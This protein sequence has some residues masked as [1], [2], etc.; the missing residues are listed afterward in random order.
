MSD[1]RK[2]QHQQGGQGGQQQGGGDQK[3]QELKPKPGRGREQHQFED[4]N[5]Q[6]QPGYGGPDD[7]SFEDAPSHGT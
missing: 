7:P 5:Y 2:Q 3:D 6:P 1:E 4:P